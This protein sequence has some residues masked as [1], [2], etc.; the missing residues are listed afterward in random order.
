MSAGNGPEVAAALEGVRKSFGATEALAGLDLTLQAGE[1]HAVLGPNGAGKT[2]A[3]GILTGLRRP[4]SGSVTVLGGDPRD[5][6]IRRRIGLTPQESGFP[7]NL[8]VGEILRLVRAHYPA[9][10]SDRDLLAAFPLEGV[11]DRQAGGLSGGQKRLL[12]AALAFAGSPE[13]VFL[14]EPTTG[15][16]VAARQALWNAVRSFRDRGMTVVLTT[17]YLEEAEALATRVAV[18]HRGVCLAS[19]TVDHI[20]ARADR[21]RISWRG[22]ACEDLPGASRT[23]REGEDVV[24]FAHDADAA[25]RALVRR[26]VRFSGLRIRRAG[27]E[28]AF[29]AMTGRTD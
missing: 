5:P 23:H 20:C 17:H 16:D 1:I 14:D 13:L 2:T 9:P 24:V 28:E 26:N 15:L 27:L 11:L 25:V 18:I 29:L 21:F 12:A 4:A 7:L 19:G 8:R 22:E 10:M 6:G 3:I